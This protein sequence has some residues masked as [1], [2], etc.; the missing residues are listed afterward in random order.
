MSSSSSRVSRLS[1]GLMESG[2]QSLSRYKEFMRGQK[3]RLDEE[4]MKVMERD[5]KIEG[6]DTEMGELR[7]KMGFQEVE[8]EELK[9]RSG[10]VYLHR[11]RSLSRRERLHLRSR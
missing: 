2:A 7:R 6:L 3:R 8:M 9:R 5:E 1:I 11:R 10:M 4:R